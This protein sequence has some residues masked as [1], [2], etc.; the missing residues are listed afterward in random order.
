MASEP[1]I[2]G[3]LR[4]IFIVLG[5]DATKNLEYHRLTKKIMK[6][7]L[8]KD[9]NCIDIGGHKGEIL[10]DMLRF[11]PNGR[12]YVF[13]PIPPLFQ[14]LKEKYS[15][16]ANIYPY[17]LSNKEEKSSFQ[18]VLNAP[19]YSGIKKRNYDDIKDPVLEEIEV[20]LRMLDSIIPE[21]E[22][23]DLVKIDVEGGEYDVLLG[24]LRTIRNSRPLIIFES[25]K[26][27][28]ENYGANHKDVF[29]LINK[30]LGFGI[31]TLRDYINNK[32]ALS[33][34]EFEDL[35]ISNKEYYFVAAD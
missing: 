1:A 3:L 26:G 22:K 8:K 27:G 5:I 10:E 25:G 35:F 6:K 15:N 33:E 9:S 18:I 14:N 21:T 34:Q 23:I 12:H 31:F 17:A 32:E 11:S 29:N 13:E 7:Y 16:R 28:C 20:E 24:G 4:K 19:A 30:E 2:K